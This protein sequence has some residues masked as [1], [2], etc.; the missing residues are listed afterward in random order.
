M[1]TMYPAATFTATR[2]ELLGEA[3]LLGSAEIARGVC[4]G[5]DRVLSVLA[6]TPERMRRIDGWLGPVGF[7]THAAAPDLDRTIVGSVC[8]H[9]QATELLRAIVVSLVGAL[10][11]AASASS[12]LQLELDELSPGTLPEG[13]DW[14]AIVSAAPASGAAA[15]YRTIIAGAGGLMLGDLA[16]SDRGATLAPA[17]V[18]DVWATLAAAAGVAQRSVRDLL[19]ED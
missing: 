14:V 8:D 15:A 13:L 6:V 17:G 4:R 3:P 11:E 19:L 10:P 16:A 9:D 7:V 12:T 1:D 5:A 18:D 2:R